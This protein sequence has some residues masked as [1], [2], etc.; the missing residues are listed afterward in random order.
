M[1]GAPLVFHAAVDH[2]RGVH[3]RV[4][5]M[6]SSPGCVRW[7]GFSGFR[8]WGST[9]Y[10]CFTSAL[11]VVDTWL[12]GGPLVFGATSGLPSLEGV[13]CSAFY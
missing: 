3:P 11:Q 7:P 10:E 2:A 5:R 1:A 12:A 4:T 13:G 6:P 8:S 9:F